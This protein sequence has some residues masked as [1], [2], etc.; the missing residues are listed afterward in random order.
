M[1]GI[2]RDAGPDACRIRPL[3]PRAPRAGGSIAA[4]NRLGPVCARR[5]VIACP[6]GRVPA[7]IPGGDEDS[8][9]AMDG[10]DM[11]RFLLILC[12]LSWGT[13]PALPAAQEAAPQIGRADLVELLGRIFT[14]PEMRDEL[15]SLGFRGEKLDLAMDH[16]RATMSDPVI[17]GHIADRVLE[18]RIGAIPVAG[19]NGLVWDL[20]DRG[21]GHL[22]L[23]DLHYFYK[24]QRAVLHG[25]PQRQCGQLI[26]GRLAPARMAEITSRAAARLNAPA[27]KTY[28]RIQR[29]AARL[30]AARAPRTLS[31]AQQDHLAR[32]IGAALAQRMR[33]DP[34]TRRLYR[35]F[36]TLDRASDAQACAAGRLFLDTVLGL[37]G[38]DLHHG[39]IYLSTP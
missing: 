35:I 4:K 21:T 9:H 15:H 19:A 32:R 29:Q 17:A 11:R 3:A 7:R 12:L 18:A 5:P 33:S 25:L 27:L 23:R 6:R 36:G 20:V 14:G 26:K 8:P 10:T 13:V 24:V 31:P 28:Y 2:V 34:Q 38:R 16:I 30:G 22:P 39:L 37:K 1:T